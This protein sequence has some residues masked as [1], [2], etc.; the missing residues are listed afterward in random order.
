MENILS[1][2]VRA[3][4][5]VMAVFVFA[6]Y[7][8]FDAAPAASLSLFVD[9]VVRT[10]LLGLLFVVAAALCVDARE[11][12][13]RLGD[14]AEQRSFSSSQVTEL[15]LAGFV[16]G[17][18][19]YVFTSVPLLLAGVMSRVGLF[20]KSCPESLFYLGAAFI[21]ILVITSVM[22]SAGTRANELQKRLRKE[23]R[24]SWQSMA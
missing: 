4:F 6:A 10:L 3:A 17:A 12:V 5:A 13:R 21:E 16:S 18:S 22:F 8:Q 15:R 2:M 20:S 7:G 9:P 19:A 1:K 23:A 24:Q 11:Q 14:L